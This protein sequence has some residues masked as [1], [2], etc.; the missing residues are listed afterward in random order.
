M[1]PIDDINP[2]GMDVDLDE[3][4]DV[5]DEGDLEAMLT[6]YQ[7]CGIRTE[8]EREKVAEEIGDHFETFKHRTKSELEDVISTITKARD[9]DERVTLSGPVRMRLHAM[10]NWI[11]DFYRCSEEP[12]LDDMNPKQF[13]SALDVA[14]Q[15]NKIRAHSRLEAATLA[16]QTDPGL[17]KG[18]RAW[19]SW[20]EA[21]EN[22]LATQ[23]GVSGVPL[24]YLIREKEIGDRTVAYSTFDEKAIACAPLFGPTFEADATKLHQKHI[25]WTRDQDSFQFIKKLRSKNNGRLDQLALVDHYDGAGNKEVRLQ[26]AI[27]LKA[28]LHYKNERV[29]KFDLYLSKIEEMCNAFDDSEQ[30]MYEKEKFEFLMTRCQNPMLQVD[31]ASLRTDRAKDP[32]SCT[33]EFA[34]NYL[35]GRAASTDSGTGQGR[36]LSA[37]A[38]TLGPGPASGIYNADGTIFLGKFEPYS[39]WT[40]LSQSEQEEVYAARPAREESGGGRGRG[41]GRGSG[42]GGGGRGSHGG[43]WSA[44]ASNREVK[45]IKQAN[46][47]L[48]KEL[49]KVKRKVASLTSQGDPALPPLPPPANDAG[50]QFGGRSEKKK[51]KNE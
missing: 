33:Y 21:E 4:E 14:A 6:A 26:Q 19:Q 30:A 36:N 7:W 37:L 13:R 48:N 1:N 32:I 43:R 22:H 45:A 17:L 10:L 15:R 41:R 31:I 16:V 38:T 9:A 46:K 3:L 2:D 5:I 35:S 12:S 42:R 11:Q 50:N 28:T 49:E 40:S 20:K 24:L 39:K 18:P 44:K 51:Q 27:K 29:L 47:N 25:A 34:A 8:E 23:L